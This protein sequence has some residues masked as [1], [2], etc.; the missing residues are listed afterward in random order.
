MAVIDSVN[1]NQVFWIQIQPE[2]PLCDVPWLG[3]SVVLSDGRVNFCCY[4]NAEVGN[5]NEEPF[6]QIWNG[7]LMQ[8]IR[9]TLSEQRLPPECQCASCPIYRGDE[10]NYLFDRMEGPNRF[11]AT[12]THDPHARIRERLQGSALRINKDEVR[13]GDSLEVSLELRYQGEP[14]VVDLFVGVRYPDG[15]IRFPPEFEGYPVP[16]KSSVNFD[17]ERLPLIFSVFDPCVIPFHAAGEYQICAALF[18]TD[19]NPNLLSNCYWSA[20]KAIVFNSRFG[21][22]A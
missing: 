12:G 15:E 9:H 11:K 19:S 3:T 10:L 13:I 5:V 7:P 6:E 4:S 17:G 21:R 22:F 18:E 20:N 8:R 14:I 16:F 1:P 2:R